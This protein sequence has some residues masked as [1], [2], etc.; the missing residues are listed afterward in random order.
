MIITAE[1]SLYA[2][3]EDYEAHVI[4]YIKSLREQP[5]IETR[6]TGMST[7][8]RG[9]SKD[10]FNAIHHSMKAYMSND[11]TCSFVV[12]YLNAD[13]FADPKID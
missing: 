1:I 2:L 9:E 7:Y 6:T 13:C 3:K 11:H 12:K 4:N 10:V 5:G 8:V